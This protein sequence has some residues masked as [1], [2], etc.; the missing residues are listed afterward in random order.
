[1]GFIVQLKPDPQTTYMNGKICCVCY[2]IT[3][4]DSKKFK[5]GEMW[6]LDFDIK[7]NIHDPKSF[8]G[9]DGGTLKPGK[10]STPAKKGVSATPEEPPIV[11]KELDADT[12]KV[13][14]CV[15]VDCNK[16]GA[17]TNLSVEFHAAGAGEW[18]KQDYS[19]ETPGPLPAPK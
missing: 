15:P 18:I 12:D 3:R 17:S 19:G 6:G 9:C 4:D 16:G 14:I 8:S 11:Y 7:L 10:P 13:E 1:M 5:K 2:I